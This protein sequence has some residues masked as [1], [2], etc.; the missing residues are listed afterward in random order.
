[1]LLLSTAISFYIN[2]PNFERNKN[3][4][5]KYFWNYVQTINSF[6]IKKYFIYESVCALPVE[7]S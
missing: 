6:V 1:M 7:L 3:S 2:I 4:L 5:K